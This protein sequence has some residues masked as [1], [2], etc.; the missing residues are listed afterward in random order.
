MFDTAGQAACSMFFRVDQYFDFIIVSAEN[1]T[2]HKY[3]AQ[4]VRSI[5]R[6]ISEIVGNPVLVPSQKSINWFFK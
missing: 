2:L 3:I 1:T 5:F 4:N 6:A